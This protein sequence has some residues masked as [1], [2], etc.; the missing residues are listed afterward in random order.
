MSTK[1]SKSQAM[2]TLEDIIGGPLKI[3][4]LLRSIRLADELSLAEFSKKLGIT[5]SH[6]CDIE[7]GRK[8]VSP[9]RAARFA[10]I[11]GRSREQFVRLALQQMI[12]DAGLKMRVVIEPLAHGA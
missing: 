10:K 1:K 5:I 6:L 2:K 12:H 11:L 8:T 7:K 3:G 9:Q 4:D